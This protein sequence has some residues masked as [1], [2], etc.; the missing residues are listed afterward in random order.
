MILLFSILFRVVPPQS[1]PNH[2]K[3]AKF[4]AVKKYCE[5]LSGTYDEKGQS[6]RYEAY[7]YCDSG[8]YTIENC[9]FSNI[10]MWGSLIYDYAYLIYSY[11][12]NLKVL[13]CQMEKIIFNE[14]MIYSQSDDYQSTL[15]FCDIKDCHHEDSDDS[16]GI[17]YHSDCKQTIVTNCTI[18]FTSNDMYGGAFQLK[19]QT[20]CK[21]L[22]NR[23][24]NAQSNEH[25]CIE[26]LNNNDK[27]RK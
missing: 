21:I 15:S 16:D 11:L 20:N 12:A 22:G 27:C 26:F 13:H 8:T 7:A 25:I 6:F 24:E 5:A 3:K 9:K 14:F 10:Q 23:F 18:H 2:Q 4:S 1:Y 19:Y 17:L